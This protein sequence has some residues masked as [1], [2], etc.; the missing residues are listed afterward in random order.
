MKK[1]NNT[2]YTVDKAG[3]IYNPKG[4]KLKPVLNT[5]GYGQVNIAG[6]RL[7][8]HRIVANAFCKPSPGKDQVDHINGVK[9]DNRASNLRWCSAKENTHFY[10]Q[11]KKQKLK[12]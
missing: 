5:K 9:M 7:L 3:N 1:I 8:V 4:R 2:N 11:N 6:M 10:L 12:K